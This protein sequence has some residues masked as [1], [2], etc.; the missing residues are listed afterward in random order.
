LSQGTL[1]TMQNLLNIS[2]TLAM[3]FSISQQ[4]Q[5][6]YL[7]LA[8]LSI[9]GSLCLLG[10]MEWLRCLIDVE[11]LFCLLVYTFYSS[12]PVAVINPA[13]V[14]ITARPTAVDALPH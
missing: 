5:V 4:P 11:P 14:I 8:I 13:L 3:N 1:H 9:V 2:F 12:I 10:Q 6:C 7:F